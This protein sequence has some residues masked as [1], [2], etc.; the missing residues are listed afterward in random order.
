MLVCRV[1]TSGHHDSHCC[2]SEARDRL[3]AMVA[4]RARALVWGLVEVAVVA[5]AVS[6]G[7]VVDSDQGAEVE[8]GGGTSPGDELTGGGPN[9]GGGSTSG[10][11]SGA[12]GL[13]VIIPPTD[14]PVPADSC[15]EL[16]ADFLD[17]PCSQDD[18]IVVGE[19]AFDTDRRISVLLDERATVASVLQ[20]ALL[21]LAPSLGAGGAGLA[22]ESLPLR[23]WFYPETSAE[24][25]G[26]SFRVLA[27]GTT[28]YGQVFPDEPEFAPY[29]AHYQSGD[30]VWHVAQ[31]ALLDGSTVVRKW[32]V[33][34]EPNYTCLVK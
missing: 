24:V 33:V 8:G 11:A 14:R 5:W 19:C 4:F 30:E 6:C 22:A 23:V 20:L 25:M 3:S 7:K 32:R 2:C 31:V 21:P 26:D 15:G 16:P 17:P 29:V 27:A 10:G 1:L 34:F 13:S 18:L 9:S 12:G 28:V